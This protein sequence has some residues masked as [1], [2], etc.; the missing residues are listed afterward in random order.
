MTPSDEELLE[1]F[2]RGEEPAFDALV[3]RWSTPLLNLAWR[4]GGTREDAE[5]IR[6]M[7]LIK[8]FQSSGDFRGHARFSTWLYRVCLNLVRDRR[9]R[10]EVRRDAFGRIRD[11]AADAEVDTTTPLTSF[12]RREEAQ[13]VADAV[14][15]LPAQIRE[16]VVLRHYHDLPFPAI[17]EILG[18]PVTTVKSRMQ[19][20]LERLR[21]RLQHL[22]A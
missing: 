9:R 2:Q 16:V 21:V 14:L 10:S 4:L 8:I 5:E 6:Q 17:A 13:R 20:G 12:S 1:R 22:E 11:E 19:N 3:E 18:A 15:A 7:A